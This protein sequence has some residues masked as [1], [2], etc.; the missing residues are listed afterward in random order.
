M[1]FLLKLGAGKQT[2]GKQVLVKNQKGTY[3]RG[4]QERVGLRN[5]VGCN[6][7]LSCDPTHSYIPFLLQAHTFKKST[8]RLTTPT[9]LQW[10]LKV[11]NKLLLFQWTVFYMNN[12]TSY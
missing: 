1:F 7:S 4:S 9:L 2:L 12:W 6:P 10:W 8:Q 5:N 11:W 3:E